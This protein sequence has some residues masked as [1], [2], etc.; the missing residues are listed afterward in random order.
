MRYG[1]VGRPWRIHGS[2]IAYKALLVFPVRL[3][4]ASVSRDKLLGLNRDGY[5]AGV[6][7]VQQ[8]DATAIM[9]H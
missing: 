7:Y 1:L 5:S 6:Q 2:T 4:T 3:I 8:R 9:A